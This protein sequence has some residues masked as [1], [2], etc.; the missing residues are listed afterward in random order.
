MSQ[1]APPAPPADPGVT[2]QL[3]L[4]ISMR[5]GVS[6]AVWIGGA[7]AEIDVLRRSRPSTGVTAS[8]DPN[9]PIYAQLLDLAGYTSVQVDVLSGAS[10]GGLNGAIYATSLMYDV[11]FRHMLPIWVRL[12][13]LESMIRVDTKDPATGRPADSLLEGD[14][15]FLTKLTTEL[16]QLTEASTEG[17]LPIVTYLDLVL[18]GTLLTPT[19]EI[20]VGAPGE[21]LSI[22]RREAFFQFHHEQDIGSV[23]PPISHFRG[24][25]VTTTAIVDKLALAGR[26]SASFPFAFEPATVT[27]DGGSTD[28]GAPDLATIFSERGA[29]NAFR[30]IDGGVLDNIPIARAIHAVAAS[31]AAEPT[32]RW[33]LYLYPSPPDDVP[34]PPP[35]PHAPVRALSTVRRALT[36]KLDAETILDD[37]SA[38]DQHN[39]EAA[40]Q[41]IRWRGLWHGA[42]TDESVWSE[43]L[44]GLGEMGA[45]IDIRAATDAVRLRQVLE[46]PRRRYAGRPD[47]LADPGT[48]LR[49]LEL[50]APA[51]AVALGAQLEPA[52]RA[53]YSRDPDGLGDDAITVRSAIDLLIG[54]CRA[55]E[56]TVPGAVTPKR[57]LY[58]RRAEA[59]RAVFEGELALLAAMAADPP[60]VCGPADWLER[61]LRIVRPPVTAAAVVAE[62]LAAL[63]PLVGALA[64]DPMVRPYRMLTLVDAAGLSA[65]ARHAVSMLATTLQNPSPLTLKVISGAAPTPLAEELHAY[66]THVHRPPPG[67][68]RIYVDDKLAGNAVG[69]FSAFLKA[70]WRINDWT[71]GRADAASRLAEAL[72][73]R[74]DA[75]RPGT[76][77]GLRRLWADVGGDA[78][79]GFV[80]ELLAELVSAGPGDA[81]HRLC[82]AV[83][84][85]L[86]LELWRHHLPLIESAGARSEPAW[87]PV[88][89]VVPPAAGAATE[90][91]RPPLTDEET[92]TELRAY[93]VGRQPIT[94]IDAEDRRRIAMRLAKIGFAALL[95]ARTFADPEPAAGT[96][97]RRDLDRARRAAALGRAV[98]WP[99]RPIVLGTVFVVAAPRRAIA[100]I[101]MATVSVAVGWWAVDLAGWGVER[102][103]VP[104]FPAILLA[105]AGVAATVAGKDGARLGA[106]LGVA[107]V[108]LMGLF[109]AVDVIP[110][111]SWVLWPGWI[112]VSGVAFAVF[113]TSWMRLTHRFVAAGLAGAVYGGTAAA[114]WLI[115][116]PPGSF[117]ALERPFPAG[118]WTLSAMLLAAVGLGV[119]VD[120]GQVFRHRPGRDA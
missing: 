15:Y 13:D 32:D 114:A 87:Q 94:A 19:E 18:T 109:A 108:A 22:G 78:A 67:A 54:A 80:D 83:V 29:P 34:P 75:A 44:A 73:D 28:A 97:E 113:G 14:E 30:V 38:L 119:Q 26:A 16:G 110:D 25:G 68:D 5:G 17:P 60:D 82:R 104:G 37:T 88:S 74:L 77:D 118:W 50:R 49:D 90:P 45:V 7:L 72:L 70:D 11:D 107:A 81:R 58:A 52:L 9:A 63:Q 93:D 42:G 106:G 21:N 66:R 103:L 116:S 91:A 3:R 101:A 117:W 43:W 8:A 6:L 102:Y 36:A 56:R 99:L 79:D 41:A 31:P 23:D 111:D 55:V 100:M 71:W 64:D 92:L 84:R 47:V 48:P 112:A 76:E 89:P 57:V 1:A 61:H 86:Q 35:P 105:I 85:R 53:T 46:H 12:A 98:L 69:N 40:F 96:P 95:P 24:P 115:T 33:L 120:Q 59:E 62:A 51:V 27:T 65:M 39:V 2:A 4:A 10:A 20:V